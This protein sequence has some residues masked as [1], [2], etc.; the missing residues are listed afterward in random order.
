[1]AGVAAPGAGTPQ[2]PHSHL[3][4]AL[5]E[6][7][8]QAQGSLK[9][10]L[11]A[12]GCWSLGGSLGRGLCPVGEAGLAAQVVPFA[13]SEALPGSCVLRSSLGL[14]STPCTPQDALRPCLQL[15]CGSWEQ[16]SSS[17]APGQ[18]EFAS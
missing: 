11:R 6:S 17:P 14:C 1:M 13:S 18:P 9:L 8:I 2:G 12:L 15:G 3:S 4:L 16:G 10:L 5:P 7:C